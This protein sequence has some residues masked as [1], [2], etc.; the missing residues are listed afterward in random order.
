MRKWYLVNFSSLLM[1][2]VPR[3]VHIEINTSGL[4]NGD[5]LNNTRIVLV[6]R[7]H[8]LVVISLRRNPQLLFSLP[9]MILQKG[10]TCYE[11]DTPLPGSFLGKYLNLRLSTPAAV[12]MSIKTSMN[13]IRETNHLDPHLSCQPCLPSQH[14]FHFHAIPRHKI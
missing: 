11:L 10:D 1:S 5:S 9:F 12:F 13:F 6:R 2:R 4:K 8:H 3:E 7:L 14:S